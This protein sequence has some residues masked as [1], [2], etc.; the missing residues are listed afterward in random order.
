M[1]IND[2]DVATLLDA[3]ADANRMRN[4][5]LNDASKSL[6][7]LPNNFQI[8]DLEEFRD[9]RRRFRGKFTTSS[10]QDFFQYVRQNA[11]LLALSGLKP[12]GF[13]SPCG[14]YAVAYFNLHNVDGEPGHA[15][16]TGSLKLD[17][18]AA[19]S[20]LL[21]INGKPLTQRQLVDFLED[22]QDCVVALGAN[23][24]QIR[25]AHA[26][27]AIQKLDIKSGRQSSHV[28]G[29]FQ[30]ARSSME[31]VE[32]KL[33]EATPRMFLFDCAPYHGLNT[34][35]FRLGVSILTSHEEPKLVLRIKQREAVEED[36]I[37]EFKKLLADGLANVATMTIGEFT[38]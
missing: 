30:A 23:D 15:D 29:N 11:E 5:I 1:S 31:E 9:S 26:A 4:D 16:W 35:T 18:T 38:P 21:A 22:W 3:G 17:K 20:A 33:T 27:A 6:I 19:Y 28:D 7:A 25:I 12:D 10:V 2:N 13:I 34:R 37:K 24:E 8:H 14:P 36:I 32:A